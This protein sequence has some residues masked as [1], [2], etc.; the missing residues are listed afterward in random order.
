MGVRSWKITTRPIE[1]PSVSFIGEVENPRKTSVPSARRNR[2]SARGTLESSLPSLASHP[3]IPARTCPIGFPTVSPR[4]MP[5][6]AHAV[7]FTRFTFPWVSIVRRPDGMLSITC[8]WKLSSFWITSSRSRTFSFP[9]RI[10]SPRS[11]ERTPVRRNAVECVTADRANWE[12]GTDV[13]SNPGGRR[14]PRV[15]R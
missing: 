2:I 11:P 14:I 10:S 15:C 13:A 1:R 9:F 6:M 3:S 5:R 4:V 8:L 7:S 12:N